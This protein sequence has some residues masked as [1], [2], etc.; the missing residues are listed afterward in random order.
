MSVCR[1]CSVGKPHI[2][3]KSSASAASCEKNNPLSSFEATQRPEYRVWGSRFTNLWSRHWA[4]KFAFRRKTEDVR[5]LNAA[6]IPVTRYGLEALTLELK[7]LKP[8]ETRY[9]QY[10]RRCSG[11]KSSHCFHVSNLQSLD[12]G[13][14]TSDPL[15]QTQ[16]SLQFKGVGLVN[17]SLHRSSNT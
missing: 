1:G 17:S 2:Y 10:L 7:H 11:I 15:S 8:M 16:N 6:I 13:T 3:Y 4:Y 5:V 9:F 14:K 12:S